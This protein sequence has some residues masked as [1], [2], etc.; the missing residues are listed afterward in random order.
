MSLADDIDEFV[1]LHRE[2]GRLTAAAGEP[3]T[4]GYPLEIAYPCGVTFE[5]WVTELDSIDDLIREHLR[6]E[7]N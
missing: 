5:R 7:R 1:M 2:H 3:T 4:N 6:A